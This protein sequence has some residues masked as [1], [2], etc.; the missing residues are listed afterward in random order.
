VAAFGENVRRR[1]ALDRLMIQG[2]TFPGLIGVFLVPG[3]GF[4][5]RSRVW[6]KPALASCAALA[7]IFIV[8]LGYPV[9]NIAFGLLMSI[10]VSSITYYCSDQ[11][12][13]LTLG[14]RLLVALALTLCLGA[15]L[16]FPARRTLQN[17]Y[18]TPLRMGNRVVVFQKSIAAGQVKRGDLVA[19]NLTE[20]YDQGVYA[21]GGLTS[22][23]VSGVPGDQI[24]FTAK[25]FSVN[26][27]SYPRLS[28]MPMSG[29]TVVPEN[30]WFIWPNLATIGGHGNVGE[31]VISGMILRMADVPQEQFAGKPFKTWFGRRQDL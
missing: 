3:L 21:H 22:G 8:W 17:H 7:I 30:H 20:I 4:Y 18:F 9:A 1:L 15:L 11:M 10:H 13:E 23:T 31:G 26:G 2:T 28:H 27:V 25:T 14:R 19:Y 12:N 16:Y 5:L 6:G 24:E 29:G